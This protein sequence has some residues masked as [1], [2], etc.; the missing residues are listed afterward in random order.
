MDACIQNRFYV[1]LL[2]LNT[3]EPPVN[4]QSKKE[5]LVLPLQEVV[6]YEIRPT[7]GLFQQEEV[8]TRIFV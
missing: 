4:D 6:A 5:D 8:S 7:W 1:S 3:V 2:L